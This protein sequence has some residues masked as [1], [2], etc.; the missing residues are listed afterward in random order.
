MANPTLAFPG[1]ID[2]TWLYP[3]YN[4]FGL[5]AARRAWIGAA[6]APSE[7]ARAGSVLT[8]PTRQATYSETGVLHLDEGVITGLLMERHGFTGDQWLD[9]LEWIVDHQMIYD[10]VMYV[11]PRITRS[12]ELV[13]GGTS[14]SKEPRQA[15][16]HAW[17]VSVPFRTL[18]WHRTSRDY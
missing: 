10:R 15:G 16:G 1:D 11:T 4:R 3:H 17:D 9:R 6:T 5:D 14:I 8:A 7:R 18:E 12:I 13:P 2:G